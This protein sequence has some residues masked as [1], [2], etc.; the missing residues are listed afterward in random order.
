LSSVSDLH[1]LTV[2]QIQISLAEMTALTVTVAM[3]KLTRCLSV[4]VVNTQSVATG[5]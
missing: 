5:H 2:R 3:H 1:L 4:A